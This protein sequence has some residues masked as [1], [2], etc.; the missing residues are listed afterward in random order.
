MALLSVVVPAYNV[1]DYLPECLDSLLG[2]SFTDI[3]VIGVDDRS[4]DRCGDILSD[5]AA[6]DPRV[7][8]LHLPE[9]RGLGGAR[10]AG[11][12]EATGEYVWF[13]DSDD[14]VDAH[15]LARIAARIE[16]T[17]PD[18]LFVGH[19]LAYWD[20]RT[21]R[22]P[23]DAVLAGL[24]DV[25]TAA[26]RPELFRVFPSAWNKV[27]RREFLLGLGMDYP[28]GA[29]EDLPVTF[30]MLCA[31]DR[32]SVVDD[33]CL[34]Y[35]QRPGSILNSGGQKHLDLVDQYRLVFQRLA[36]L[37]DRALVTPIYTFMVKHLFVLLGAGRIGRAH[38]HDYFRRASTLTN[39]LRPA[40]FTPPG[41]LDG[42]RYKLLATG[43]WPGVVA[44]RRGYQVVQGIRRGARRVTGTLRHTAR[45]AR[46][47]AG[48]AVLRLYYKAQARGPVDENL[49]LYC[50]YWG[51]GYACNPKA[52]YEKARELAPGVRGVWVV[53]AEGAASLPAGVE[54]VVQDTPAFYRALARAKYLVNN[55]NFGNYLVKRPGT[56][57][58]QTHHGTPL[59]SMGVDER[60]HPLTPATRHNSVKSLLKR[61][62]AWDYDVSSNAYSTTVW[63]K[64][65]PC[66]FTT[67][68]YGYPRND[69]L[70]NTS[71]EQVAQLRARLGIGPDE[72]VVLYAPTHRE[73]Q[74]EYRPLFDPD[75]FVAAL[76]PR[77]RLLLRAHYF[78]AGGTGHTAGGSPA[79]MDVSDYPVVE[80][81]YLVAD[82][83][84]TDYS[85]VMFDYGV[86]DR[87]IVIYAP[88][89][90]VYRDT[91][92]AYFN[93]AAAPPGLFVR[94]YDE[95]VE[96]FRTG[97][98]DTE[99]TRALRADFRDRFCA[100]DDGHAADRL[101]RKV[102]LGED[103]ALP[104]GATADSGQRQPLTS[105]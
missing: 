69:V 32:I 44:L 72:T 76:G 104:A 103:P 46:A 52:I 73:Y 8:V 15:A 19:A 99:Q 39:D 62:A 26:E 71:P 11:L 35:R 88:D 98:V 55:N 101:V 10:N 102:M 45:A 14:W 27:V 43:S 80:E 75:A 4:P 56:V 82:V 92:G 3:E 29:Y 64:A 5:Y 54:Y 30:P 94:D 49:A 67:L 31:A 16:A 86:L 58:V 89:W 68:E 33:V 1:E 65:Y 77:H 100:Y 60:R 7:K 95:L 105:S 70:V 74:S 9:N 22:D 79:V 37:G 24:P 23:G 47:F 25:C 17:R 38:R 91:R 41:G 40:G 2:Q 50:A 85:S 34:Y 12:A 13:V 90:H 93:L 87:P 81:L 51:R 28:T 66:D 63:H 20:L 53:T 36:W 61:C 96:A 18:V 42:V 57:F 97:T 59:K 48:K 6:R 21:E 84:V 78:Y 83:L